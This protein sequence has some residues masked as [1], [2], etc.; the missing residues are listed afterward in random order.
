VTPAVRAAYLGPPGTFT[1]EAL[2]RTRWSG[3]L[4]PVAVPSIR[5]AVLTVRDGELER[6]LVPIENSLEGAVTAT[7]DTLALEAPGVLI[8]AE[9]VYPITQ[10]LI[11]RAAVPLAEIDVVC[12][13]PQALGQC[14]RFLRER[15]PRAEIRTAPSTA[16]AVRAVAEHAGG[17][18]ALGNR[19]AAERYDCAILAADV[20]DE[21]EN[22]TR[23]VWLARDS[24]GGRL[25]GGGLDSA[26]APLQPRAAWKTAVV[27]W[28]PGSEAPGWLVACLA[29]LARRRVNLT[30]IESRPRRE[31]LGRYMFFVDLEGHRSDPDVAAGLEG[32]RSHVEVLRVLGCFP[33]ATGYADVTLG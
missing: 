5:D 1:H 12:S 15:L 30:R 8:L 33:A 32:L 31:G 13:H 19:L 29:E 18:G 20:Q 17:W 28:G 26:A 10:C 21:P 25:A 11:A 4:E 22:D 7:L 23:F 24:G 16:E 9:L 6:A 3:E 14:R 27:F 2:L